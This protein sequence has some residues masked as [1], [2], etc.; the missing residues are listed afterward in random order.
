MIE[1]ESDYGGIQA[2]F[3]MNLPEDVQLFNEYHALIVKV[4]SRYCKKTK[5][6]CGSCPLQGLNL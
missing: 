4:A 2:A 3:V 6:L 1:E 5:P